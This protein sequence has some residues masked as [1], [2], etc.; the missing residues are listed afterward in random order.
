MLDNPEPFV[1]DVGGG[2]AEPYMVQIGQTGFAADRSK[3][4]REPL[5]TVVSKNEHC[6]I[7]P[8]LI[9]YHSE[10]AKD[11]V[12]GQGIR[13]PI[14]TVDGSNRYGLVCNFLQK[15]YGG[16]Y[17]GKGN[18]LR[19]PL[20]TITTVDHN[21]VCAAHLVQL[22]NNCDGRDITEPIPTIP[23]GGG[24]F[25]EVRAFLIKFYGQGT[26]Q[27]VK[28][29]LDTVTARDRFGLVTVGGVDYQIVDIGLRMLEP[30]ELYGCQGFPDDYIID[31]DADGKPYSRSEQVRRC[32]NAVCPPIPA[33]LVRANLPELCK[34]GKDGGAN[35]SIADSF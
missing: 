1:V 22:N 25:G 11:E 28:A 33:A 19:E 12:R 7:T 3:D 16:G 29:P 10:T 35:E 27:D 8:T 30:R 31:R 23:A 14:M 32:G 15:Y 5:T 4:V 34:V 21:T 9:Q 2:M 20:P 24:H 17:T 18:D 13:E 26:G 6:L